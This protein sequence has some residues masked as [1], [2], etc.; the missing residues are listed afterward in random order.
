MNRKIISIIALFIVTVGAVGLVAYQTLSPKTDNSQLITVTYTPHSV[1]STDYW[2]ARSNLLVTHIVIDALFNSGK[3]VPFYA[4]GSTFGNSNSSVINSKDYPLN[5][6]AF[7]LT[8]NGQPL[9]T[10]VLTLNK[11]IIKTHTASEMTILRGLEFTVIG[12]VTSYQLAYNGT[13]NVKI[14]M[15]NP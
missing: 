15:E 10:F 7:Y 12:N 14:I 9:S 5:I 2:Y 6:N 13:Q 1:A 8:S 3:D 11:S 4:E